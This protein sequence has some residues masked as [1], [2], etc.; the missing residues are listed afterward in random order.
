[1]GNIKFLSS[2][3]VDKILS[4]STCVASPLIRSVTVC[5]T[6]L[7][8]AG[9]ASV[10]SGFIADARLSVGG[11]IRST[12]MI[13]GTTF[14]A[15]TS[16]TSPT[17]K[18]T[19]V[20]A[21]TS[22]TCVAYFHSDGTIL[23]GTSGGGIA[24]SG[25][26]AHGVLTYGNASTAV[27]ESVLTFDTSTLYFA[28]GADRVIRMCDVGLAAQCDIFF[29]GQCRTTVNAGNGTAGG[30]FID[31]GSTCI[32]TPAVGGVAK[33]R[34][35]AANSTGT[36]TGGAVCIVGGAGSISTSPGSGTGGDVC[37]LGGV[38]NGN[39]GTS[40]QGSVYIHD[41]TTL[42]LNTNTTGICVTGNLATSSNICST[43][44]ICANTCIG[45]NTRI[46]TACFLGSTFVCSPV[47]TG[48]TKV[49][50][51]IVLGTTCMV[52]PL[53]STSAGMTL[54]PTT[55]FTVTTGAENAILATNNAGVNLYFNNVCVFN[56]LSTGACITG[57]G[58]AT[59]FIAASDKRLKK[60][61]EPISN[62]LSMVTQLQGVCYR[63][64]DDECCEIR[65]GLIAQDVQEVLPE[66]V[67]HTPPTNDD[68]KYGIT[69][70]KLGLKY[71]KIVSVLIEAIKELN[72]KIIIL[73]NEI[74]KQ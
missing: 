72:I 41:G 1:M 47:I 5:T 15:L 64:C 69:D 37:L 74:K 8:T 10:N 50:S 34:G 48:S 59:D 7:I 26:T 73:E 44:C 4:G 25:T 31:G 43:T 66:V 56:T 46:I 71:D 61:I 49:C 29:V 68:A 39:G 53:I 30:V 40:V 63:M 55:T 12:G 24:L 67:T 62:A 21:K 32:I 70:E 57:C 6:D 13:S 23:S 2:T 16:V 17:L 27:V 35:G 19:N 9:F 58:F 54:A 14:R 60:D 11:D 38:G 28:S 22:E 33:V 42:R 52:T 18:L 51:P 20:A 45:A 36:A 3:S 65:V